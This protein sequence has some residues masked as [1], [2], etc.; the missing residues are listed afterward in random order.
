[1]TGN[2]NHFY[3]MITAIINQANTR[4]GH[5]QPIAMPWQRHSG[6]YY[7]VVKA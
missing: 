1:M 2:S 7:Q 6:M 3:L 5:R 4:F